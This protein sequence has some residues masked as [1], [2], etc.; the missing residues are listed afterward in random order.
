MDEVTGME[1]IVGKDRRGM[2][3]VDA[4]GKTDTVKV[5]SPA[6]FGWPKTAE[7][8]KRVDNMRCIDITAE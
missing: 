6:G 8:V 1:G 4:D 2:D 7:T 3:D 5:T